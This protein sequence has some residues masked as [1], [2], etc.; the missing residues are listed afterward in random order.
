MSS[1]LKI[2]AD[3]SEVKKSILDL[4]KSLKDLKGTKVQIFSS[5]D[6]KFMKSEFKKEVALMKN[7]LQENRAEINK[8]I[9]AQKGMTEGSKEELEIR[10]KILEAY[11][12]Q[13][14]L[15][16]QLGAT[17]KAGKLGGAVDGAGSGGGILSSLMGL[18]RMIP[19]LAAVA[20]IGY[21]LSK[22]MQAND[23]YVKGAGNRNRL[24]GLGVKDENFGNSDELARVGLTEQDMIQ[25]RID[26]TATLGREGT[27][28]KTEMQKAG[29]ERAY[30]L[31]GGTMTGIAT[32]FRGQMG[33]KGATDAQMKLQASVLAAGI[34]D[35]IG[36][37]LDSA[38]QLLTHINE[39]GMTNTTE[40]TAMLAQLTKD[41]QRTPEMMGKTFAGINDSV[42]GATGEGSAFLQTAF[43]RAGIGGGTIG[44][45][46]FSMASGGIMGQ[47]R[48]ELEK[49]GYNKELLDNMEKN[50]MFSGLG[51]RTTAIMDQM[52]ASGGLK[53]GENISDIKDTDRM[54]GM[55]NLASN[56]LGIKDPSQAFDALMMMEQ[57]E[58]KQMTQKSFNEKLKKMQEGNDPVVGRLD[59]IN[60]TLSGQTEILRAINT[61]RMETLGKE[62]VVASNAMTKADNEGI[63]G[64]KNVAGAINSTGAVE[65]AGNAAQ[66]F[67][68]KVNSGKWGGD[69]Y[70]SMFSKRDRRKQEEATSDEAVIAFAKKRRDEGTGFKG[71]SDDQIEKKVRESMAKQAKDIGK[72]I[73]ENVKLTP[74]SVHTNVKVQSIDGK[75][76]DKTN[77]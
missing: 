12:T 15:G 29:F 43:A 7:K 2:S 39:N 60:K 9:E 71:M 34:E 18:A 4:G 65:G 14:K 42:K 35:A 53:P 74:P 62:A 68:Q 24:K 77:R 69:L 38:V 67:G 13:S 3:T 22:G 21:A 72:A 56:T 36:P 50:G 19:G 46:K 61:N 30:G 10:K 28:N 59:E 27:S 64:I 75:V 70:D 17:Q 54:V 49:R 48:E 26:A 73:G 44:G 66:S 33:G 11:K 76:N 16:K 1:Q 32:Q 47:N 31:E 25:R 52:R 63:V 37:Y 55:G 6:K 5:E 51:K 23:Q 45:T 40:M 41:G 20:T 8:M 57:V 58:K